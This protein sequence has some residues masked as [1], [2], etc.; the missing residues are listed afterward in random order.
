MYNMF[1]M[2][3]TE[4]APA[5][6]GVEQHELEICL[7]EGL[8]RSGK[9][10]VANTLKETY[11]FETIGVGHYW[12]SVTAYYLQ[13]NPDQLEGFDPEVFTEFVERDAENIQA[14]LRGDL[15]PEKYGTDSLEVREHMSQLGLKTKVAHDIINDFVCEKIIEMRDA[16]VTAIFLEGRSWDV[17]LVERMLRG[18]NIGKII[19]NLYLDV[20]VDVAADRQEVKAKISSEPFDRTQEKARI[21]KRNTEDAERELYPMTLAQDA[22]E[23]DHAIGED[24]AKA[25]GASAMSVVTDKQPIPRCIHITTDILTEKEVKEITVAIVEGAS[26]N[27]AA[28]AL[29]IRQ[30]T[31][32]ALSV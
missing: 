9:T 6:A 8:A 28:R 5:Q 7:L 24:K 4:F 32:E 31:A 16:G 13:E 23:I 14:V 15:V 22:F 2:T 18:M 11:G 19:A 26:P 25:I 10:T 29:A 12:R 20:S 27:L 3:E 30:K 1:L 21:T 17:I